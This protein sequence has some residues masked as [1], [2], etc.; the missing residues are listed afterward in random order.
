M[1][2][3]FTHSD[4]D[5]KNIE[6]LWEELTQR[7]NSMGFGE[8]SVEKWMHVWHTKTFKMLHTLYKTF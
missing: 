8:K 4:G 6:K 7:L 5:N 2:P 3:N 1:K